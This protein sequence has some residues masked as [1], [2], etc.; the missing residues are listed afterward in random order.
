MKREG[1]NSFYRKLKI[2]KVTWKAI[3]LYHELK[4][5]ALRALPPK[6]GKKQ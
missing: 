3:K 1:K 2:N 5:K 6:R 4:F